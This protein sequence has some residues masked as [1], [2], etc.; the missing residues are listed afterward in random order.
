[1][2]LC[3]IETVTETRHSVNVG[4]I[5]KYESQRVCEDSQSSWSWN[6]MHITEH[7]DEDINNLQYHATM[8]L[9][10]SMASNT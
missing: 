7:L 2:H 6:C 1:M 5:G 9:V 3:L 4:T 8:H 10:P